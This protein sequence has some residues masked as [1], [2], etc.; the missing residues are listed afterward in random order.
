MNFYTRLI[1]GLAR[2]ETVHCRPHG[3]S[4]LP[5]IRSGQLLTIVPVSANN[6]VEVG[7][8]VLCRVKGSCMVHLVTA[9]RGATFQ[10]SNNHGHVN[11]WTAT[12]YGVVTGVED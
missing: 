5:K 2:G 3:N 11:G 9:M 12:I 6:P 1:E 8:I 4:M 10:I 7:S